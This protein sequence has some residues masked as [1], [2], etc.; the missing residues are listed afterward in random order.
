MKKKS[1]ATAGQFNLT[2][3]ICRELLIPVPDIE[4]Q[5][6]IVFRID[7]H[8]SMCDSIEKIVDTA[9]AQ[10]EAMRQSVLKEAFEGRL[11]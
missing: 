3:E 9:L 1:K 4:E 2:L 5:Y 11:A 7:E 6:N 10:A 8:L